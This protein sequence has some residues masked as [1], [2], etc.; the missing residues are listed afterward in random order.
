MIARTLYLENNILK[1]LDQRLL[2]SEIYYIDCITKEDTFKCIKDMAIRGAPA[3]GVAAGYGM[4][5]AA[6]EKEFKNISE[7][8]KYIEKAGKYLISARPTA[9][10]LFWGVD[11]ILNVVKRYTGFNI[12]ELKLR[13][14][15]E[16]NKMYEEDITINKK[17]GELGIKVAGMNQR[18]DTLSGGNQQKLIIAREFE[19]EPKLLIA[20]QPTRGVDVGAI[21]FIHRRILEAREKGAGVLLVSSELDEILALA[22]RILVMYAGRIVAQFNRGEASEQVLGLSMGGAHA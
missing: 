1:I 7:I 13:I 18:A 2:P 10:N 11:R 16:A 3:I 20:A 8:K 5:L 4:Y 14:K 21:E 17:I 9:V 15:V 6:C 12:I 22:D 19:C